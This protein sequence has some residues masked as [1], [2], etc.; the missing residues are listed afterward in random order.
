MPRHPKNTK[1]MVAMWSAAVEEKVAAALA[2][3]IARLA[4]RS[5]VTLS[6]HQAG[7]LSHPLARALQIAASK[8]GGPS[9]AIDYL[10]EE[11]AADADREP[12]TPSRR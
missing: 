12:M 1:E 11:A 6:P 7:E 4:S 8:G 9:A 5:G 3:V 2:P 10:T